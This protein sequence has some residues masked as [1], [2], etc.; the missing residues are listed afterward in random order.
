MTRKEIALKMFAEI[1]STFSKM[2]PEGLKILQQYQEELSDT[3]SPLF[4]MLLACNK[5]DMMCSISG[6]M[7]AKGASFMDSC[8]AIGVT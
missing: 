7:S 6:F 8:Y 2:S 1:N 4:K 3:S 5:R